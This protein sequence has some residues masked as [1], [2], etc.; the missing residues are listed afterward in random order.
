MIQFYCAECDL[1]IHETLHSCPACASRPPALPYTN[2]A[3]GGPV[4]GVS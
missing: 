3:N 4:N 1:F 2:G